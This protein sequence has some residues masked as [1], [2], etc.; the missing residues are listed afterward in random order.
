MHSNTGQFGNANT[1]R[2][3][4]SNSFPAR[5]RA[6]SRLEV[7]NVSKSFKSRVIVD[8]VSMYVE[9]GE[10]VGL[11]GANG[12]GK[13][14]SFNLVIGLEFCDEGSIMLD[15]T[16]LNRLPMHMRAKLG[17]GYLPQEPSVFRKLSVEDNIR[18]I[19][20]V[21]QL[22]SAKERSDRLEEL[23]HTFRIEKVRR[24]LGRNLSGG[25]RRRVEIA[26]A[27]AINPRFMLLDEP[28]AGVD[29]IAIEDVVEQIH[30]LQSQNVGVLITDH[31]VRETLG[32]CTRAYI[33][34]SG[35]I[36]VSGTPT[37][38]LNDTIARNHYLGTRFQL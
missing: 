23:L 34:S 32:I 37:E 33:M 17:I 10:I 28:F 15:G 19:L 5:R 20:E 7:I 8:Q 24:S 3:R 2:G 14:T 13:T 38:I 21:Q 6:T 16:E 22:E 35:K 31:N 25:E 27:F 12:A 36:I 30:F 4:V 18:A 9:S 1:P 11:M 26:R 29:P